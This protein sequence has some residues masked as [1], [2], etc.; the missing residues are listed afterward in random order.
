MRTLI[1]LSGL[2]VLACVK[3]DR[4]KETD[5]HPASYYEKCRLLTLSED[6][7]GV[8]F[9]FSRKL[10]TVDEVIVVYLGNVVTSTR[11]TLKIVNAINFTGYTPETKKGE[12]AVYIYSEQHKLLGYYFVGANWS[13]PSAVNADSLVFSYDNEFCNQRTAISLRDSIPSKIFVNCTDSGGD[14]Y[15][16]EPN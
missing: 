9:L 13:L 11:D 16:F 4:T 14:L 15:T 7:I 8:E 10:E 5:L 12:G 6:K 2:L 3:P 1:L